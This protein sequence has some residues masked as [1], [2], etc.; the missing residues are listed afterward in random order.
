MIVIQIPDHQRRGSSSSITNAGGAVSCFILPED[1]KEGDQDTGPA[2]TQGM[3]Q[4]YRSSM[5]VDAGGVEL[6]PAGILNTYYGKGFVQLPIVDIVHF[7]SP[8]GDGFGNGDGR[9]GGKPFRR[10]FRIGKGDN[11]S[12][13]FQSQFI[14]LLPAHQY[15]GRGAVIHGRGIGCRYRTV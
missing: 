11:F 3:P 10:L 6:H 13:W 5:D 8:Q 2:A 14:R 1:M 12:Q 7:Q 9:R 15:E 4:G